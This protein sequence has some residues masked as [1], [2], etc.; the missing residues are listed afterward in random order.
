MCTSKLLTFTVPLLVLSISQV[1][2]AG[3]FS[4]DIVSAANQVYVGAGVLHQDYREF[5]DGLVPVLPSVLDSEEGNIITAQV[6]YSALTSFLYGQVQLSVSVGETTY[7]GYL[8]SPGPV[9]TPF[10][11]P[12]DN[13]IVSL[14]GR[15]GYPFRAGARAVVVPYLEVGEFFWRRDIGYI[16]DYSHFL[17][18]LGAKLL[19]SPVSKLVVEAGLGVGTT[20]SANMTVDGY[21]YDLGSEPYRNGYLAVDYRLHGRWH[22]RL[23]AD[24]RDWKYAQSPVVAGFL[25][26]RSETV[27]ATY[28]LSAGYSFAK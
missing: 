10:V 16:E 9:Y 13:N 27:H 18:G 23:S 6:G 15:V 14:I 17:I 11:G 28:M 12:T 1:Q 19:W 25:E 5:N 7:T 21:D 24:Y 3:P 4:P 22:L 2:A 8:V 26:P 20:V